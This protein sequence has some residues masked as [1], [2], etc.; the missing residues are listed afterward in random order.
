VG[1]LVAPAGRGGGPARDGR[2]LKRPYFF[3]LFAAANLAA[4]AIV[5]YGTLALIGAPG[6]VVLS[7]LMTVAGEALVGVAIR[8]AVAAVTRE[9][10]YFRT[11]GSARWLLD[12]L[13]LMAGMTLVIFT[14]GW[15][16]LV[17]PVVHP[18]L[19]DQ[20][21]W[22]L[23]R[24]LFFGL[25]P[26]VFVLDLFANPAMLRAIDWSYASIF[27]A[28]IV[29]ASGYFLSDPSRRIRVGFANGY[30]L[31]WIS[32]A[33]LYMLVPSL[34]PA[35]RL[36]EVWQAHAELRNTQLFQRLLMLNYTNVLRAMSGEPHGVISMLFGIGAF[37]SLHVAF[38]T[39]VFLWMRR[40]WTSGQVLFGI[41]LVAI[42]LG[43]MITGWHYLIDGVA[44]FL[45]AL[46]CYRLFSRHAKLDRW[47]E[48]RRR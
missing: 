48:L 36:P 11:I 38:Q 12:T 22:E 4:I 3:E 13:R 2:T 16:K 7:V 8:A 46:G 18:A 30:A 15:I 43:S 25:S 34:G 31:L 28:S 10:G 40:L 42:F 21:L 14:Y 32:G 45:L 47:L 6:K 29:I 17:V 24:L 26:T 27:A 1:F 41:F 5:A 23:D 33:W 9:R 39:Y 35:Y 44:G 20:G 19:F 37:P